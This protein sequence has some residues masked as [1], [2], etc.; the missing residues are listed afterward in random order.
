METRLIIHLFI[1]DTGASIGMQKPPL[2]SLTEFKFPLPASRGLWLAKSAK[3]WR[4]LYHSAP[5]PTGDIL[6]FADVMQ[7]ID[8]LESTAELVDRHLCVEAILHGY[9]GQIWSYHESKRFYPESKAAHRLCLMTAQKEMY[10]DLVGSSAHIS[11]LT[12]GS[13]MIALI[14]ELLMM[15]LHADPDQLQRFAGKYGEDEAKHAASG[16]REWAQNSDSRIAIW[17]AGQVFAVANKFP[18]ARLQ[19]FSA[20]AVYYAS[21]TLWIYGLMSASNSLPA[22]SPGSN[23]SAQRTTSASLGSEEQITLNEPETAQSRRFLSSGG[24]RPVLS[25]MSD[26]GENIFVP[27]EA[28]DRMLKIARDIYKA[29]FPVDEAPLPPLVAN[30]RNLLRDLSSLPRS[31]SSRAT[32]EAAGGPN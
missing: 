7:N 18:T 28:S 9:W 8:N 3:E 16:F 11:S 15:L 20:V 27:L 31:R 21:L 19:G 25:V 26:S 1:H 5:A 30:L 24:G 6:T 4:E 13:P 32:S 23:M 22:F 14:S 10:R 17:H 12:K 2:M 29:N